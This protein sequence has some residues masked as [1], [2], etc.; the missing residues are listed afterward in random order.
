MGGPQRFC[1]TYWTSGKWLKLKQTPFPDEGSGTS[2]KAAVLRDR[3][4]K[5]AIN[6]HAPVFPGRV[7][8]HRQNNLI[9]LPHPQC[10]TFPWPQTGSSCL[11]CQRQQLGWNCAVGILPLTCCVYSDRKN[12]L[13]DL[14]PKRAMKQPAT[15]HCHI[16]L[17]LSMLLPH[18]Q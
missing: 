3:S 13:E 16:H 17:S 2:A 1:G 10:S 6:F 4:V 12:Q 15:C 5:V 18:L 8:S 14:R 7:P 11:T 9:C